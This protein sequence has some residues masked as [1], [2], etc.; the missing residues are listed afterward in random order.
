MAASTRSITLALLAIL[1]C[2]LASVAITVLTQ[3]EWAGAAANGATVSGLGST[4]TLF[5]VVAA[6]ELLATLAVL[7]A[8]TRQGPNA[9]TAA[10]VFAIVVALLGAAGF[11]TQ[12]VRPNTGDTWRGVA[13]GALGI[14]SLASAVFVAV[15]LWGRRAAPSGT[16][17]A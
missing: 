14:V 7:W 3:I 2:M 17:A 4:A 9:T 16:P 6:V 5:A 8:W 10:L 11:V 1:A 13:D 15:S 12:A